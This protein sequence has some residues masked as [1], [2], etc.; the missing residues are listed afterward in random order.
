MRNVSGKVPDDVRPILKPWLE[1]ARDAP[2]CE[3]GK[4]MAQAVMEKFSPDSPSAMKSFAEDLE[5]SLVHL[6]LPSV[7]RKNI[8][9]AKCGGAQFFGGVRTGQGHPALPWGEGVPKARLR[10]VLAGVGALAEGA[11]L[12]YRA[13][14]P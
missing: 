9:P 1:A 5:A 13:Q 3:A 8:R 11:L 7:H 2:A 6:M 10:G 4:R 12:K 14:A